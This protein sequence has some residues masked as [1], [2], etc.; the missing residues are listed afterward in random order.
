MTL[1]REHLTVE[2]V[3]EI[4]AIYL[5]QAER[6]LMEMYINYKCNPG[7]PVH[8]AAYKEAKEQLAWLKGEIERWVS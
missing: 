4:G 2:Q 1:N 7:N 5:Q 6:R 8:E 3:K